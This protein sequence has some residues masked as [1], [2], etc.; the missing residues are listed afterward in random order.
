MNEKI[1]QQAQS[2]YPPKTNASEYVAFIRGVEW[3]IKNNEWKRLFCKGEI[4]EI[5]REIR[6]IG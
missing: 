2:L 6:D 1:K 3:A 5:Q 4:Q